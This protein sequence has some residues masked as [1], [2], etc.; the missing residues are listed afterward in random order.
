[1][2]LCCRKYSSLELPPVEEDLGNEKP[3]S[4]PS[5]QQWWWWPTGGVN[6][7]QMVGFQSNHATKTFTL[8]DWYRWA[9]LWQ[10]PTVTKWIGFRVSLDVCVCVDQMGAWRS[11]IW[12]PIFGKS[13]W[14]SPALLLALCTVKA[15]TCPL[16]FLK[17]I[18]TI[19]DK[20]AALLSTQEK[21]WRSISEYW[22]SVASLLLSTSHIDHLLLSTSPTLKPRGALFSITPCVKYSIW[23]PDKRTSYIALQL[24]QKSYLFLYANYPNWTLRSRYY[25]DAVDCVRVVF[26]N[27]KIYGVKPK[28]AQTLILDECKLPNWALRSRSYSD[29]AGSQ[30]DNIAF[31]LW[32]KIIYTGPAGRESCGGY[33]ITSRYDDL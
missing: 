28:K 5:H 31:A 29:E 27:E 17:T 3:L 12:S 15:G 32:C 26:Q 9:C 13:L 19:P 30:R 21:V 20:R 7:R 16:K 14:P 22:S 6:G 10:I 8:P 4:W 33:Y 1:M 24:L 18:E 2:N 25:S 11:S 23:S